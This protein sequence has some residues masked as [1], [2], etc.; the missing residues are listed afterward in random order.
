MNASEA[1]GNALDLI[2][3]IR[4]NN[5]VDR[6]NFFYTTWLLIIFAWFIVGWEYVGNPIECW[7]PAYYN[8]S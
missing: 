4:D 8:G 1:A 3:P 5:R 2:I 6:L 7:F